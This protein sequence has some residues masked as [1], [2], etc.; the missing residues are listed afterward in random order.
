MATWRDVRRLALS[1]PQ[2]EE[3]TTYGGNRAWT[4]P[5]E[6]DGHAS[7]LIRLRE[8]GVEL[9]DFLAERGEP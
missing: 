6:T 2:A 1:L 7:V 5:Q 8:I 9:R 4:I 3:S